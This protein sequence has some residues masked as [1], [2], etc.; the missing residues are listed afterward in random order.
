MAR[1]VGVPKGYPSG[2]VYQLRQSFEG[3]DLRQSLLMEPSNK[4]F[5]RRE[6]VV[7][8]HG[9]NNHYGEAAVAYEGF[10]KRQ[11]SLNSS[12]Q[13]ASLQSILADVHWP[14]D[15][16]WGLFDIAD[17][18]VYPY[19]VGTAKKAGAILAKFLMQMPNLEIVHFI[20]HSLG[21]RVVL[22]TIRKLGARPQVGKLCLMAAAVPVFQV[23]YGGRL[24]SAIA[25]AKHVLVLHSSSDLVLKAAFP[26]GQFAA[27]R[28]EGFFPVALGRDKPPP[29]VAGMLSEKEVKGAKHSDYWGHQLT[30]QSQDAAAY[31]A[32][33]I[34]FDIN[35]RSIGKRNSAKAMKFCASRNVSE[36]R[37]L[38]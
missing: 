25:R 6:I 21:C 33:F 1:Y 7:L 31:T 5:D 29:T 36:S 10:R 15:A 32:E 11:Y 19:A 8:V 35:F 13:P 18:L 38:G 17:F 4:G 23:E 37:T 20:G 9:F 34:G 28:G 26:P 16:A 2:V 22:E 14:G 24:A 3:G 12:L 30:K 27:G